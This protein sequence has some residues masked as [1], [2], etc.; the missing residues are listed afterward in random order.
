MEQYYRIAGL[1]VCMDSFGRNEVQAKAYLCEPE[2][3]DIIIQSNWKKLKEQQP[4]LSEE[5]CEYL[6]AGGSFYRQLIPFGGM[7]LH[8]SAVVKDGY[9]YL[10]SAPCGTGKSTHTALWQKVFGRELVQMLNDDKPA[11]RLEDGTWF[12]YGTPWSGKHDCSLNMR[13]PVG[14]IC[15]LRQAKQNQIEPLE[16][17]KAIFALL[18]QTV[19]PQDASLRVLLMDLLGQLVESVSVWQMECN[20]EPEAAVLSCAAMTGIRMK[21]TVNNI[22]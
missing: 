12:A 11:L 21:E 10:F 19:R 17:S 3:P 7:M 9:A 1:T 4:H 2:T 16:G 15:F 14:G 13:V 22:Y 20:M 5:D 6:M 18:D 8:A